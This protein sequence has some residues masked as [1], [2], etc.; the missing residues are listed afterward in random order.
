MLNDKQV[1]EIVKKLRQE[2]QAKVE[3]IQRRDELIKEWQAEFKPNFPPMKAAKRLIEDI[4]MANRQIHRLDGQL[5][6]LYFALDMIRGAQQ[7][8]AE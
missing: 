1:T 5:G 3:E 6:T 8:A 2:I 7:G 4:E